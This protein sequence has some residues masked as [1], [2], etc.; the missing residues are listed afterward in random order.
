MDQSQWWKI[1]TGQVDPSVETLAR[2]ASAVGFSV[3]E[4]LRGV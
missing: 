3:S 4:L 2:V 1:E